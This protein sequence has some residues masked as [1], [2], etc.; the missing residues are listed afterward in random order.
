M[1]MLEDFGSFMIPGRVVSIDGQDKKYVRR[2]PQLTIEID[3]NGT[4]AVENTYVEYYV[5]KD[6]R[7][8]MVLVHGGGLCG[9][10]WHTTPDGRK[11]FVQLFLENAYTVYVVDTV[12]RGRAGWCAVPEIWPEAAE[13]RTAETTWSAFRIGTA[14]N[15]L[16]RKPFEHQQFPVAAFDNFVCYQVPRWDVHTEA[17]VTGLYK[18]LQ[19]IDRRCIVLGHSQGCDLVMRL[20]EQQSQYISHLILLEP[21]SCYLPQGSYQSDV[22]LLTLWGDY[23]TQDPLWTS[24]YKANLAYQEALKNLGFNAEIWNLPA[25]GMEGNSHALMLDKNNELIAKRLMQWIES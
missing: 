2:N 16:A 14:Q 22:R 13:S 10:A 1:Y 8:I 25:Q 23:L 18:L 20:F 9:H 21:S 11:G 7:G 24:I 17:S 6:S 15:F 12:E 19:K 4:Y 5:P 3:P